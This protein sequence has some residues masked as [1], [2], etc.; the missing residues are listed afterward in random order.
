ME[1]KIA[2]MIELEAL[3]SMNPGLNFFFSI[4]RLHIERNTFDNI[5]VI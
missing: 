4:G 5:K 2:T 1:N 3:A